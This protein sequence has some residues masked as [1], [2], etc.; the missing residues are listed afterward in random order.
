MTRA[1]RG[2]RYF[3][4]KWDKAKEKKHQ[5]QVERDI[6]LF[7]D[8]EIA[9]VDQ[10]I[11]A[12]LD[13]LEVL[14]LA[15]DTLVV[16]SADHGEGLW[17]H[18]DYRGH[19][20]HVYEEQV[21]VPLLVRWPGVTP[22]GLRVKE[23]VPILDVYGLLANAYGLAEPDEHQTGD[24]YDW[25]VGAGEERPIFVEELLDTVEMD[26]VQDGK[27]KLIDDRG[28][29]RIELYDLDA[30]PGEL[31]QPG[32]AGAGAASSAC[33]PCWRPRRRPTR[34]S[35]RGS[36][37][38]AARPRSPKRKRPASAPSATD[39]PPSP[40]PSPDSPVKQDQCGSV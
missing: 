35:A 32:R 39:F 7:Y 22:P 16:I 15:D 24:L 30:D 6:I 10:H 9:W 11:G 13:S 38:R 34:P 12:V 28:R 21:H 40:Q 20:H 33:S 5:A 3:L 8:S 37:S 2:A 1:P 31:T 29:E 26:V 14:G 18:E 17:D 25:F 4:K 27:W 36:P 23:P 19:G